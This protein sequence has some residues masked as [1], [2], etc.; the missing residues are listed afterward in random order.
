M[1][2][3]SFSFSAI[4][5]VMLSRLSMKRPAVWLLAAGALIHDGRLNLLPAI[6]CC[7]IA[8]LL[9]AIFALAFTGMAFALAG[10]GPV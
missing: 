3:T 5:E 4:I 9:A 6:L 7:M 10:G 2:P 1:I 8:V